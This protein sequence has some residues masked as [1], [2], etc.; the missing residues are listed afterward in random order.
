MTSLYRRR[1]VGAALLLP[2]TSGAWAQACAPSL[3]QTEGPFFKPSSPQRVTLIE[4]GTRAPR[5]V[6]TGRVLSRDC[7]PLKGALLDFWH[8]DEQGDYD[9][10]GYRYRGHQFTDAEGRWRLETIV[11]AVYPGRTR[12]IHVKVQPA[13]G[14]LLTTQLYFPNEPQNQRDG[15]FRNEL[16]MSMSGREQGAFDFVVA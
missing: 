7:Q 12:H 3:R 4:P 8:A 2:V 5:L 14:R 15:L 10:Q 1:L 9:N 6:V 13:G 16:V 11:P